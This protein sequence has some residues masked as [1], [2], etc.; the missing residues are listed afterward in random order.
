LACGRV[1]GDL[2]EG[3]AASTIGELLIDAPCT[4]AEE[5]LPLMWIL[6]S[7]EFFFFCYKWLLYLHHMKN[8]LLKPSC[9]FVSYKDII[10]LQPFYGFAPYVL[11]RI[12]F[13][14]TGSNGFAK[15]VMFLLHLFYAFATVVQN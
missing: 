13:A 3:E 2:H 1:G 5:G 7:Y 12:F 14:T 6:Q 10:L 9:G 4:G 15:V 11:C 8:F